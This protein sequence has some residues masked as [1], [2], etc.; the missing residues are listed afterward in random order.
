[1]IQSHFN[2]LF[3]KLL[4]KDR[5]QKIAVAVSG[6][7]D[8]VA[9]LHLVSI[10]ARDVSVQ[11]VVLSVNHNLRTESKDEI[12]YV[13]ELARGLQHEFYSLSWDCGERKVAVQE[14]AREG[15]YSLMSAKCH[16]LGID[17]LLTGHHFDDVIETYLMRKQKKSGILGLSHSDSFFYDNI[18]VLRPLGSFEKR[19]LIAYV[20]N[21]GVKWFEDQSNSSDAYERNRLRKKIGEFSVEEKTQLISEI[22]QV[23]NKAK[24]LGE[25]FIVAMAESVK[26]NNY[27]FA[28]IDLLKLRVESE[29]IVVQILN[30]VLTII[31]GKNYLPRFRN[32]QPIMQKLLSIDKINCSLHNCI[33]KV[34][35]SNLLIFKEK[36]T[37][38]KI[39]LTLKDGQCFDN[40]FQLILPSEIERGYYCDRLSFND[41]LKIK[42]DLDL[43]KLAKIS[44]N[45]HKEILFTL[46]I[47][48][49]LEKIVAIPHI[50]YYDDFKPKIKIIFRPNFISR[51][52]HFL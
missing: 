30:Y 36:S 8:S 3:T 18:R 34:V 44:D 16:E 11:I 37:I 35:N 17:T 40:K 15:R 32:V 23:N 46:P 25:R 52:T 9:L 10:W 33:L 20:H 26:I 24:T 19:Q 28:V 39:A 6:G 4:A 47:I 27:G 43:Q 7:V 1:M 13:Q 5:P 31:S 51:F 42:N 12:C 45:N 14:R 22:K 50:S 2:N 41:Y 48:K 38:S 49:N 29:D 21:L